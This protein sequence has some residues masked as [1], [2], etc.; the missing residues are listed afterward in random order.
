M[1]VM[2]FLLNMFVPACAS[3]VLIALSTFGGIVVGLFFDADDVCRSSGC[4]SESFRSLLLSNL[5]WVVAVTAAVLVV[6]RAVVLF[7]QHKNRT[8]E[9][10]KF[11]QLLR[12]MKESLDLMEGRV[13]DRFE[14]LDASMHR[15]RSCYR[16][17]QWRSTFVR[18]LMFRN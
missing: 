8:D 13:M 7:M 12:E 16:K 17:R 11:E 18:R 2:S 1:K 14:D 5:R 3:L 4:D 10:E 9:G 6:E 15:S